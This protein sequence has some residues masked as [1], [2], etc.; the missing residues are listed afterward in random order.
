MA[1]KAPIQMYRHGYYLEFEGPIQLV[2]VYCVIQLT[3]NISAGD[4]EVDYCRMCTTDDAG[5]L[6]RTSCSRCFFT[7]MATSDVFT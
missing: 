2:D 7:M 6:M 4:S 1:V 5:V 3:T